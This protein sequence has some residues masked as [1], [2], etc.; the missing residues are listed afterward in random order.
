MP[1]PGQLPFPQES[2]QQMQRDIVELSGVLGFL[3]QLGYGNPL[4]ITVNGATTKVLYD[5]NN[6]E[7]Y[8]RVYISIAEGNIQNMRNLATDIYDLSTGKKGGGVELPTT[9]Y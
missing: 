3:L 6:P 2:I 5:E 4:S 1:E 9:K 8:D 7:E